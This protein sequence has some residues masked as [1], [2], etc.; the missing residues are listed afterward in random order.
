MC[1]VLEAESYAARLAPFTGNR[2]AWIERYL[3][4]R[5]RDDP[6]ADPRNAVREGE[7]AWRLHGWAHPAVIAQL[8]RG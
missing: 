1:D 2:A 6:A 3:A 4:A 5:R 7:I 8:D